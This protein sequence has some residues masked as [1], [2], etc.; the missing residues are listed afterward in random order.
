M[1]HI[2]VNVYLENLEQNSLV[3][4]Q[5]SARQGTRSGVLMMLFE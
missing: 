3:R 1:S 2:V 5:T 4:S